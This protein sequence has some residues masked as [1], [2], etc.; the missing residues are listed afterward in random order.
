[1]GTPGH[2]ETRERNETQARVVHS[3]GFWISQTEVTQGLWSL[4]MPD[5]PWRT[6]LTTNV[7]EGDDFPAAGMTWIEAMDF[8]RVLTE[9]ERTE[10]RLKP[11]EV[12]R[13]PT[14]AE[15][16]Y[17]CRAG[18][19]GSYCFGDDEHEL[20]EY[21]WF[22]SSSQSPGSTRA[23]HVAEKR[24]NR[25]NICDMHGNVSEW[26]LDVYIEEVEGGTD[27]LTDYGTEPTRVRR[28]GSFRL[29]AGC[30]RSAYR[31]GAAENQRIDTT[32]FRFIRT[33]VIHSEKRRS[34]QRG[35][36]RF[37]DRE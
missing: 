16:E 9:I 25:W 37:D 27:P 35:P 3:E 28:G 12:Y 1:M 14:E 7:K 24:P 4:V 13:L 5:D 19:K 36:R 8:C 22:R 2:S 18:S 21:C 11:N 23:S 30:C 17:A 29:E 10:G 15:W 6:Y 33:T 31:F 20:S 26:C 34:S 32:G